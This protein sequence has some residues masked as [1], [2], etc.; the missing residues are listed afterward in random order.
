MAPAHACEASD[1][2]G[3]LKEDVDS[4]LTSAMAVQL[5]RRRQAL[6]AGAA[7]VGSKL[8]VGDAERIGDQLAV[9]HLT[10]ATLLA[11][12]ATFPSNTATL[13]AD[14]EVALVLSRDL[15]PD[16]G[17]AGARQAIAAYAAAL[18]LVDLGNADDGAEAV[19]ATN[20]FHRAVAFGPPQATM[21]EGV[22]GRLIVSGQVR[23]SAPVSVDV[24]ARLCAAAR[25]LA[26]MGERLRAGD[27]VITGSVVQV[28][29]RP[30][31]DVTADFGA[32]GRVR[33]AI[34]A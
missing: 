27:R 31:D 7:R 3:D 15:A 34:V 14:A 6:D 25:V 16:A 30:G 12:G 29:V 11:A 13:N 28:Q 17:T 32:L 26:G 9:G 5:D 22:E 23:A 24:A 1:T 19:I 18:E 33:L 8:G 2:V 10:T 20:I 4:R 21:P